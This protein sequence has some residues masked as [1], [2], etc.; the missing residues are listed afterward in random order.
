[1][2]HA[3][4]G[5]AATGALLP[6]AAGFAEPCAAATVSGRSPASVPAS[7]SGGGGGANAGP[8]SAAIAVSSGAAGWFCAGTLAVVSSEKRTYNKPTMPTAKRP[9]P[10]MEGQDEEVP[11]TSYSGSESRGSDSVEVSALVS[12]VVF[13]DKSFAVLRE[14]AD[15]RYQSGTGARDG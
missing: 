1:F 11:G 2:M 9:M 12:L 3:P 14:T 4:D 5:P 8:S 7:S 13:L 10:A 15:T 6:L